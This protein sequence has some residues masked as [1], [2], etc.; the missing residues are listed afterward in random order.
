MARFRRS[1]NGALAGGL[2][3]WAQLAFGQ[4]PDPALGPP[5]VVSPPQAAPA[6]DYGFEPLPDAFQFEILADYEEAVAS[7]P[8][9][10]GAA[11]GT[12]GGALPSATPP[13]SVAPPN[14]LPATEPEERSVVPN[15]GN[16][17]GTIPLPEGAPRDLGK[18][19]KAKTR[20]LEAEFSD[21][22]T[23]KSDDGYFSLTFHNLTQGDGRFF[24]PT[25]N[26]LTDSFIIPRQRWYVLGNV[27]PNIRYYTVINRGYGSL[28][29]LDSFLDMN[30]G[31]VEPEK[32]QFRFG[33]MKTPYTYEYIKVSETELI[34]PERSVFVGNL[35]PNREIGGMAHGELLEKR[36]EYAVGV[37]NGPRR[38]FQDYNRAK[39]LFTFVNTK[40]FRKW[41]GSPLQQ[42][43][44]GG[45]FNFGD[46]LN[47]LQPAA[48]RTANDQSPA[49]AAAN[50]SPTFLNFN[51]NAFEDGWRMQ[52]SGD[53]TWYYKAFGLM[54]GYQG[55]F[56]DYGVSN[57]A[58]PSSF[59]G[60]TSPT[61]TQ[62]PMSGWNLATWWFITGEQ[63]TRRVFLVEP[64]SQFTS[65]RKRGTGAVELFSRFANIHLGNSVFS[66]GLVNQ[67]LWSNNANV[68]DIGVNWYVNHYTK[69]TLDWQYSDFGK[70]VQWA[71]GQFT[72]F[73]NLYWLRAQLFF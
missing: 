32:L 61:K 51:P 19:A 55:G 65:L 36:F 48:L 47:P 69:L 66:N 38:S 53:V 71:P 68:T 44:L 72:S 8:P 11:E 63:I 3:A 12:V 40:P 37:F 15:R 41:E 27:S 60:V 10:S 39:D 6:R 49:A 67:T 24:K 14:E 58:I 33:R 21:G 4:S 42:L 22:L 26:P 17:F 23:V 35:V 2:L 20:K 18:D 52:W 9:G 5:S 28:D 29:L 56:Q 73:C 30:F 54:A 25:G 45:S 50:V 7:Q 70:P 31:L 16:E 13:E 64:R 57:T 62:V 34:A 46:E 43:N 59:V 1:L